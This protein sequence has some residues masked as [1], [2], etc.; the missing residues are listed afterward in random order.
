MH[1]NMLERIFLIASST[2]RDSSRSPVAK[3]ESCKN[4]FVTNTSQLSP[5]H[6][7]RTRF[8]DSLS[9]RYG[10]FARAVVHFTD[11][12]PSP[13]AVGLEGWAFGQ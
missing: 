8:Y 12:K 5:L 2:H 6:L 10:M 11:R 7:S 3:Q 4:R 1:A 13:R 9:I